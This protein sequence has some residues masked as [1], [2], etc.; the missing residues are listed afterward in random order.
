[1]TFAEKLR[2]DPQIRSQIEAL[3]DAVGA[4]A[5]QITQTKPPQKERKT[6]YEEALSHLSSLR[7]ASLFFPY[8][9]SGIGNGPFVELLD[10][11]VKYDMIAGIGVHYFGHSSPLL[12]KASIEASLQNTHLQGNLQ[13]N[14]ENLE[15]LQLLQEIS[16]LNHA[17]LTTSGVMANENALKLAFHRHPG[18]T[19]VLAFDRCFAGRTLALSQVTDKA[20]FRVGLPPTLA[21]DYVPYYD[22]EST[23][24]SGENAEKALLRYLERY[25][26]QHAVM[27]F[28]LVQGEGG[29]YPGSTPFFARL[30]KICKEN[31]IAV[32]ADEVQTFART[33]EFFAYQHFDL[34][35]YVDIAAIGKLS[36]V[37][38]TL[39]RNTYQPGP[40]L[41]SQTFSCSTACLFNS[42]AIIRTL[43]NGGYFGS[44]GRLAALFARFE[45]YFLDWERKYPGKI[46]GPYGVGGMIGFTPF[47]GSL[48]TAKAL[49]HRLFDAGIIAYLAGSHPTRIRL[50][51]PAAILTDTHIDDVMQRMEKIC[52]G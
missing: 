30:M 38:A 33:S 4:Y 14:K 7:G 39:F 20:M 11:S 49:L 19:R 8:I 51:P 12:I 23:E 2:Q 28:E 45:R 17:F 44:K 32:F 22:P 27:I 43:K 18:A 13:Q 42:L 36:Q 10:G 6:S 34:E 41:L 37:C 47:D 31:N 29:I 52:F 9:G 3:A 1:M 46:K 5:S 40:A 15:L 21:V 25:P 35:E 24:K 50:L 26:K 48:E 16:G